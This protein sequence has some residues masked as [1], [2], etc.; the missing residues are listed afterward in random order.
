MQ[1]NGE[2]RGETVV[3]EKTLQQQSTAVAGAAVQEPG[4]VVDGL[5]AGKTSPELMEKGGGAVVEEKTCHG[6]MEDKKKRRRKENASLETERTREATNR[7][8]R[9]AKK[10]IFVEKEAQPPTREQEP[11]GGKQTTTKEQEEVA[12]LPALKRRRAKASYTKKGDTTLL[13]TDRNVNGLEELHR[14]LHLSK[15]EG[16]DDVSKVIKAEPLEER[17]QRLLEENKVKKKRGRPSKSDSVAQTLTNMK[18]TQTEKNDDS[19]DQGP[20]PGVRRSARN[21]EV[22]VYTGE[23]KE[24]ILEKKNVPTPKKSPAQDLASQELD[25]ENWSMKQ[26]VKW[27]N[28]RERKIAKEMQS[29]NK[30]EDKSTNAQPPV[31]EEKGAKSLAPKVHLVDGKVVVDQ[32][33][34]VVNAQQKEQYTRV[35][36][37]D[38]PTV[39]SMSYVNRLSNDR[40]SVEDTEL[41]FR[42]CVSCFRA[43]DV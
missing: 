25:S 16:A 41:F 5:D 29:K 2:V 7:R 31:V 11:E 14:A 39:N 23:D 34:L 38:V 8:L 35:V 21:K 15:F 30:Q 40:W 10:A 24:G 42:V 33:S 19:K 12:V 20:S 6:D 17:R 9:E 4:A 37:E 26:I 36:R 43:C 32:Q 18:Y 3:G 22:K 27:G 1:E 28:A 13:N